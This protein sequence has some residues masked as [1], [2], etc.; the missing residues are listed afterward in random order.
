[1]S[2][3]GPLRKLINSS[4]EKL[5]ESL[6]TNLGRLIAFGVVA[7][8][9]WGAAHT[10]SD[11][12]LSGLT[13]AKLL[14][15]INLP[16]SAVYAVNAYK[17]RFFSLFVGSTLYYAIMA[18]VLASTGHIESTGLARMGAELTYLGME[19]VM[20]QE[21]WART[22]HRSFVLLLAAAILAIAVALLFTRGEAA[23]LPIGTS[24]L[25]FV[26][27]LWLAVVVMD[28]L[29]SRGRILLG[30]YV[31]GL[32]LRVFLVLGP[33][34]TALPAENTPLDLASAGVIFGWAIE[35]AMMPLKG[36]LLTLPKDTSPRP[37]ETTAAL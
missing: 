22:G 1:M 10:S 14:L 21:V 27:A 36:V 29:S 26:S 13:A 11:L 3:K 20:V 33:L 32:L 37:N 8:A 30:G 12:A 24:V 34:P 18:Y 17:T 7:A 25:G 31:A 23:W 2:L 28:D 4:A 15:V 5:G 19:I 6:G 35:L 9:A 16:A